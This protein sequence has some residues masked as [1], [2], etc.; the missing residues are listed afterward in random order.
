[1]WNPGIILADTCGATPGF[2][3]KAM[4]L[5]VFVVIMAFRFWWMKTLVLVDTL[6]S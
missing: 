4:I 1:M 3:V 6:S 2:V 5:N